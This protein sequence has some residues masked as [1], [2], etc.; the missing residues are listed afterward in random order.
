[1]TTT[2]LDPPIGRHALAFVDVAQPERPLVIHTY[3]PKAHT[4]EDPVVLVQHGM[5]RNGEDYRDYWID[6]AEEHRLLI[7]ATTFPEVWSPGPECY[8]N[9][10]I[11]GEGGVVRPR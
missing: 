4:P 1:M 2:T 7:V 11:L 8:N 10:F 5:R 6:A 9:G 3:R